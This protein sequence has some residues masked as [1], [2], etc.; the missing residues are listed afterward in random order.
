MSPL[1]TI[2]SE[3]PIYKISQTKL[4]RMLILLQNRHPIG[5]IKISSNPRVTD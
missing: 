1:V 2:F 4:L 5:E 3:Q